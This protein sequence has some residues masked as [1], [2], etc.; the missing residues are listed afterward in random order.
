MPLSGDVSKIIYEAIEGDGSDGRR[1][2]VKFASTY[3]V[4]AHRLLA[5]HD[6]APELIYDGTDSQKFG[7]FIMIVMS[8]VKGMTLSKLLR[9]QRFDPRLDAILGSVTQEMDLLHAASLVFGDLRTPNIMVD[10]GGSVKL[11]DFDWC[12]VDGEGRYPFIIGV[13]IPWA[14]GV[15]SGETTRKDHD[16][17]M[18]R[19]LKEKIRSGA[20][21][22]TW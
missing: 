15:G 16:L 10:D 14:A 1:I 6:L 11:V 21:L 8:S 13:G 2:V 20:E 17:H 5:K 18:L 4:S 7:G 22:D 12:G 3:N 9:V 19:Q